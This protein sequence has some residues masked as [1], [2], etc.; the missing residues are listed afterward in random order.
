MSEIAQILR[1]MG[2]EQSVLAFIFLG[3][4]AAAMG[5]LFGPRTRR[6]AVLT[7]LASAAAFAALS[8]PWEQGVILVALALVGTGLFAG[9]V[10]AL[11][12]LAT[13]RERQIAL[14]A[15][16][17]LDALPQPAPARPLLARLRA[18]LTFI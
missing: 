17:E 5:E 14:R 3:S 10:W 7:A 1:N 4:Y 18:G 2:Q 6:Y 16:S 15:P 8:Q 12:T 9:T 11:W 13:W